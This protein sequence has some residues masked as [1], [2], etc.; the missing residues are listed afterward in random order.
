MLVAAIALGVIAW[1]MIPDA[2]PS[3]DAN[4]SSSNGTTMDNDSYPV[5][6]DPTPLP[7][8]IAHGRNDSATDVPSTIPEGSPSSITRW[9]GDKLESQLNPDGTAAWNQ[10]ITSTVNAKIAYNR[11]SWDNIFYDN[12]I[13]GGNVKLQVSFAFTDGRGGN[14][15]RNPDGIGYHGTWAPTT[16]TWVVTSG[17][18]NPRW[19]LGVTHSYAPDFGQG[20]CTETTGLHYKT[21]E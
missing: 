1:S 20:S 3:I 16:T 21:Y 17:T 12:L 14:Y 8:E 2:R 15:Q 4:A 5:T 7:N 19:T 11:L 18:W 13:G 10:E 6:M 9:T